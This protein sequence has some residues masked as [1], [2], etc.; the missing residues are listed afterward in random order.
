MNKLNKIYGSEQY[1]QEGLTDFILSVQLI[2]QALTKTKTNALTYNLLNNALS[3]L[4]ITLS[5]WQQ[6]GGRIVG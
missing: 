6:E 5:A 1:Y 3:L 2:K 4:I